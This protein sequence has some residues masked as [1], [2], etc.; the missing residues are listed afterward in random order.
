[1]LDEINEY[2]GRR[3]R[4]TNVFI[5]CVAHVPATIIDRHSTSIILANNWQ[6]QR[7]ND[8]T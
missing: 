2:L 3:N 8:N 6:K 7:N 4:G 5:G 1:M